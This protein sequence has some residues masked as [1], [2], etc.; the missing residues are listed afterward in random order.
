MVNNQY[1][2]DIIICPACGSTN[3]LSIPEQDKIAG[4]GAF[5]LYDSISLIHKTDC[6]YQ[7]Q[8]CFYEW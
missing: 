4:F 1:D 7:C 8:E 2:D 6:M 5:A 3:I